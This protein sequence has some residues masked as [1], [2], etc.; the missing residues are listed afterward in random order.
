MIQSEDM[1]KCMRYECGKTE[2]L[3]ASGFMTSH[4]VKAAISRADGNG[5]P[6]P[7]KRILDIAADIVKKAKF[8]EQYNMGTDRFVQ[9]L[10]KDLRDNFPRVS[11]NIRQVGKSLDFSAARRSQ[12]IQSSAMDGMISK[13]T[14][15]DMLLKSPHSGLP[16][17]AIQLQAH[18]E[19]VVDSFGDL[20]KREPK[21][22]VLSTPLSVE[23]KDSGWGISYDK[24]KEAVGG[25]VEPKLREEI[26]HLQKINQLAN[27]EITELSK[28]KALP[29]VADNMFRF[30]AGLNMQ[31]HSLADQKEFLKQMRELKEALL[32]AGIGSRD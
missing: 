20:L 2:E 15:Q 26:V 25:A 27:K 11:D 6:K 12:Y 30:L 8:A 7:K 4:E 23:P 32:A 24:L 5:V 13:Q 22:P 9:L 19:I 18:D 21:N 1:W 31:D 14:V 29:K 3:D 16:P 28:L 17:E 10:L